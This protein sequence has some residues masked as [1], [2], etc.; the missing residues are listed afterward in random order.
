M[1]LDDL[2]ADREPDAG[3]RVFALGVQALEEVEE[4]LL[5]EMREVDADAVVAHADQALA[6]FAPGDHVDA[7]ALAAPKLERVL[8]EVLQELPQQ[9]GVALHHGQIPGHAK[10]GPRLADRGAELPGDLVQ[11]RA[12]RN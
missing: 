8:D 12:E 7:N 3:P 4:V 11:Q 6:T 9:R 10:R 5:P 1:E 2:L